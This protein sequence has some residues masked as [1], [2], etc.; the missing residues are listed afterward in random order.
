MAGGRPGTTDI[1]ATLRWLEPNAGWI[2]RAAD[3]ATLA[4]RLRAYAD[5]LEREGRASVPQW[6]REAA[7]RLDKTEGRS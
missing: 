7:A 1:L 6:M 5:N 3:D 2:R 4:G